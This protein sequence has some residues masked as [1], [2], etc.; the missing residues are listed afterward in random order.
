MRDTI[1]IAAPHPD[2]ETLGCGATLLR[3][4]A[5]GDSVHWLIVTDMQVRHGFAAPAVERRT[6]EIA[7]VAAAYPFAK[8]HNLGLV[9]TRLDVLPQAELVAAIAA[10]VREVAPSIIY[11][12]FPGDAH[13]D[14]AAVFDAVAA[15][16][17][18]FRYPGIRRVLCYET[19]SETDFGL[20][21]LAGAFKP[22]CFV[23]ATR[24][25]DRK[26][27]IAQLYAGELGEFPFPR[28]VQALRALAQVRGAACGAAAAEAFMLLKEIVDD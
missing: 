20:D 4:I 23:D 2:D 10:V 9:P 15:C 13:S 26:I 18:W 19:P 11:A 12:P 16:T 8:V 24:C 3:H 7:A 14:H 1:L 22:N 28:S 5:R 21:P 17:K 27:E 25:I 6:A